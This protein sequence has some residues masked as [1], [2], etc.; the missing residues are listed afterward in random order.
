[1]RRPITLAA[2]TALGLAAVFLVPPPA[3][4]T[5]TAVVTESPVVS[6]VDVPWTAEDASTGAAVLTYGHAGC[7]E[8][9]VDGF[10]TSGSWSS[11]PLAHWIWRDVTVTPEEEINGTPWVTFDDTLTVAESGATT[12]LRI[13]ADDFYTVE[14]NGVLVGENLVGGLGIETYTFQP[15]V[16]VNTIK[17][18][19]RSSAGPAGVAYRLDTTSP[20]SLKLTAS[21][22]KITYGKA[23]Q[24]SAHLEGGTAQSKVAVYGKPVDR[25]KV[26]IAKGEVGADGTLTTRVTP[27]AITV[28]TAKYAGETGWKASVSQAVTVSVA[29]RWKARSIGGY[30]TKGKYRLY[31]WTTAC[32]PP[33]YR[34]CPSELYK[35]A[36]DHSGKKVKVTFQWWSG[37]RW[38]SDT[39]YW[40]LR[41]HSL[42]RVFTWYETRDII[43]VKHRVKATF[44]G[45]ATHTAAT[46]Q[47]VYWKVTR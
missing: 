26:L 40:R 27:K 2:A 15:V 4:A 18:A 38:K 25:R 16:G 37:S 20:T 28:F 22:R 39:Y 12:K 43:G 17:I 41:E 42:I 34:G 1:M 29:G 10:C 3:V 30:D 45:D 46:S 11:I 33:D 47:W 44:F 32:R 23:V 21:D 7:T 6:R 19:V 36:P 9:D 24:L 13:S 35:L 14:V 8:V 31:H 5:A